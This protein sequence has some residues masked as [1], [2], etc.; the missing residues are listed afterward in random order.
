MDL[1]HLT[2][3]VGHA[4]QG[5]LSH[6]LSMDFFFRRL[7]RARKYVV[8][9][10][11][12]AVLEHAASL[13]LDAGE[14]EAVLRQPAVG[15][16][17]RQRP[18]LLA[19]LSSV[20]GFRGSIDALPE[21]TL[22]F[23]GPAEREDGTPLVIAGRTLQLY[24]PLLQV[25]TDMVRSKLI[26]TP[27]L[28]YV[29]HASMVA[30]KAARVVIAA[31]GKPVI[32]F[33][34]RRTHPGAAAEA[35]WAAYLAGC[36][37]SS[38]VSAWHRFGIPLSGTMDH[39]A[40][41]AAVGQ[42]A[43]P[44]EAERSF[45]AAFARDFPESAVLL[46]DTFDTERGI[47]NAVAATGGQLTGIRLDSQVT[48]GLVRRAR[49]LLDELGA[50]QAKI[51]CS[52]KLDEHRIAELRD[53]ADGFGVG[54]GLTTSPDSPSGVGA[55]AKIVMNGYGERTMKVTRG[56]GKATLPG[57]LAA[58]RFADHDFIGLAE[59][60]EP[61]G[62]LRLLQ[63]AWRGDRAVAPVDVDSA[64]AHVREQLAR[65]PPH[66]RS[67]EDG[68]PPWRMVASDGLCAEVERLARAAEQ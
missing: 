60:P 2:T 59:E 23:A 28:G 47:R 49:R 55:V 42:G 51:F 62:G 53:D 36:A 25:R 33:G 22:A 54:E 63:P 26:E 19:A 3:L 50:T 45:F 41:Q 46:V 13:G 43:S 44:S 67:I 58:W 31:A 12:R 16:A 24:T 38:N 32:E 18:E 65:L 14:L 21:G 39:F 8:F 40:V 11:L 35:A 29:N 1:Y 5:R 17:I 10:G 61:T 4:D 64:R 30:S 68:G 20:R 15:P 52:D 6:E 7:P 56:S 48:P 9:A 34:A 27:W 37:A 66:L 57:P